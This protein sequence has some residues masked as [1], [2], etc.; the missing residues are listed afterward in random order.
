[1]PAFVEVDSKY[2]E[3]RVL[4]LRTMGCAVDVLLS[5]RSAEQF[6]PEQAFLT[7]DG[8]VN[9]TLAAPLELRLLYGSPTEAAA[10]ATLF[11]H[12][13]RDESVLEITKSVE[14]QGILVVEPTTGLFTG[15][16]LGAAE[17]DAP[18]AAVS[19]A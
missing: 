15:M 2:H 10:E 4:G 11:D 19:G 3:C 1:M 18:G 7:G 5:V 8:W 12:W 14:S 16:R 17:L 9:G 6:V 13:G